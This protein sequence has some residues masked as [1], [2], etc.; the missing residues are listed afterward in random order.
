LVSARALAATV[1]TD[2][3]LFLIGGIGATG[4]LADVWFT[5]NGLS[6]TKATDTFPSARA[7][8]CAVIH[9]DNILHIG[10]IGIAGHSTSIYRSKDGA[11]WVTSGAL[12]L[13]LSQH[14]CI[15]SNNR[16]YITGGKTATGFAN[17]VRH[18]LSLCF[19]FLLLPPFFGLILRSLPFFPGVL[20]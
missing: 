16:I 4:F 10:G 2:V 9:Y 20:E 12:P 6:W 15:V 13:G 14:A 1:S 17:S 5:T 11:S 3:A 18:S 19:L 7:A 8:G